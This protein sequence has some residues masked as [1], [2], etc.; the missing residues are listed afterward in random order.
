MY[1]EEKL[2]EAFQNDFEFFVR[3]ESISTNIDAYD[4]ELI[5]AIDVKKCRE[6]FPKFSLKYVEYD[7]PSDDFMSGN[8]TADEIHFIGI[9]KELITKE[10]IDRLCSIL[11]TCYKNYVN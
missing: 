6:V 7:Y 5:K 3:Y 9:D 2:T 8:E 11:A 10:N 1:F 4:D